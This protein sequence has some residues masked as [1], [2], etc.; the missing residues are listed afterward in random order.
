MCA[1]PA[2]RTGLQT[3]VTDLSRNIVPVNLADRSVAD[4]GVKVE[5]VASSAGSTKGG[6]V[7]DTTGRGA[8]LAGGVERVGAEG[9]GG[10]SE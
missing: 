6:R 7:A 5:I 3:G 4:T 8:R 9:A 1:D 2:G 10:T